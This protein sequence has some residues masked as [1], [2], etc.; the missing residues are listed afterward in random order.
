MANLRIARQRAGSA[1]GNVGQNQVK[2]VFMRERGGVRQLAFDARAQ[3]REPVA[4]SA[5]S[6]GTCFTCNDVGLWVSLGE[7][8]SLPA[9]CS[10][11]IQDRGSLPSNLGHK[12]RAFIL[13]AHAA[14][15]ERF[16]VAHAS[17]KNY[18]GIPQQ[19][20]QRQLHAFALELAL[21]R[22]IPKPHAQLRL[23]LTMGADR[24]GD[25]FAEESRPAIKHP[26]Q[27]EAHDRALASLTVHFKLASQFFQTCPHIGHAVHSLRLVG[28]DP[29]PDRYQ[30]W[31]SGPALVQPGCS[32]ELQWHPN[33]AQHWSVASLN[34]RNSW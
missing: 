6:R 10:A 2:F 8:E 17:L 23:P 13:D 26:W 4:Q 9:R 11:A 32:G 5:Q 25:F 33:V 31:L 30:Q 29:N 19:S 7:D 18:A 34:A 22:G 21:C 3:K 16:A 15:A 14:R 24:T 27:L 20:P 12:L 1:A 28:M